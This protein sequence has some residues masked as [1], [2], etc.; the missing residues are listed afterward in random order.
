[1][2]RY[3]PSPL[4]TL[5]NE[6]AAVAKI[7]ENLTNIATAMEGKLSRTGT[8]LPNHMSR[9]LDMNGND[10]LNV[11]EIRF[12]NGTT[13]G[14]N[15]PWP[16]GG[17][18][19]GGGSGGGGGGGGTVSPP[20][21]L[22]WEL[23]G[24]GTDIEFLIPGADVDNEI[25]YDVQRAG[26]GLNPA[27]DYVVTVG[28]PTTLSTITFATP[29]GNGV[30]VWVVLRGSNSALSLQ[31]DTVPVF[32]VDTTTE[33]LD[34]TFR[35]GH[36]LTTNVDPVTLAL[37]ANDPDNPDLDRDWRTGDYFSVDQ[38]GDGQ[39]EVVPELDELNVPLVT[40]E[41]PGGFVLKTRAKYSIISFLCVDASTNTWSVGNDL[42]AEPPTP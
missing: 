15:N 39:A 21:A 8:N 22:F 33:T 42:A 28:V 40:I 35:R 10:I 3:T 38:K 24:N 25:L 41:T 20:L 32:V 11:G 18:G 29:P 34:R 30:K 19:S 17:G 7:N 5:A 2:S 16:G 9:D 36:I 12:G 26:T 23:T 14:G 27:T 31:S 6:Q 4:G 1:M 13:I 37:R